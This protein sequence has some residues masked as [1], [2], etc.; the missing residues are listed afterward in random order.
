VTTS[1][2]WETVEAAL[3]AL[4]VARRPSVASPCSPACPCAARIPLHHQPSRLCLPLPPLSLQTASSRPKP[5]VLVTVP[6]KMVRW[7]EAF[8]GENKEGTGIGRGTETR[9]DYREEKD[10][11]KA[12]R[13]PPRPAPTLANSARCRPCQP[14]HGSIRIVDVSMAPRRFL[15]A[16]AERRGRRCRG[17]GRQRSSPG[18][19]PWRG[20][21]RR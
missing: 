20:R 1:A 12:V 17:R 15:L 13:S 19:R 6:W 9:E 3:S 14:Q 18:S 21:W 10:L 4:A 16:G 5:E 8:G 2:A 7:E 11:V